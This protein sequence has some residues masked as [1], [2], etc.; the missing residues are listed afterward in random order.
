M[1]Y[2]AVAPVKVTLHNTPLRT[3]RKIEMFW[4]LMENKSR[5]PV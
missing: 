1:L 3:N 4:N 2:K 5:N